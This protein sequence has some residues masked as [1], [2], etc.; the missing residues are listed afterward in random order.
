MLSIRDEG[1]I[2]EPTAHSF[3]SASVFNPA[4]IRTDNTVHV[5]YRAMDTYDVSSVGYASF[6]PDLTLR[7]RFDHPVLVPQE[8]WEKHGV[9][10]P[11][12]VAIDGTFYLTYVAYD[13]AEAKVAYATSTDL[14]TFTKHGLISP[15]IPYR[16]IIPL[17]SPIPLHSEYL[18]F[19]EYFRD[20]NGEDCN[21]IEKN[22]MLFPKKIH[23]K[24]AMLH[25]IHPGIQMILFDDF[26]QLTNDFWRSYLT[27]LSQW[28]VLDPKYSWEGQN[29]GAGPPPVETEAGWLL[30][31]NCRHQ[32]QGKRA[33]T[34][35]LDLSYAVG[36]ALL[37]RD[38]PTKVLARLSEPLF[39]PK[40]EWEKVG[41]VNNV[42]FATGTYMEGDRLY[43][44]YGAADKRIGAKSLLLSD[45][46]S[47]LASQEHVLR[48]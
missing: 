30:L 9:E 29:I 20:N 12:I 18:R 11:R 44:L 17:M 1:I 34:G 21:L 4:V 2:L 31:Y 39:V 38:D 33:F 40:E 5:F 24:F 23:G 3:E 27:E 36:A 43:I 22:A 26:S 7:S 35:I 14:V 6:S 48:S 28:V 32:I 16:E 8:P 41:R 47:A 15:T 46:L 10:D 45:F 25:R 42:V 13:G 37:D 19:A